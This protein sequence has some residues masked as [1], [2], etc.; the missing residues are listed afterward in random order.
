MTL[1]HRIPPIAVL[2]V[3]I[4]AI[5]QVGTSPEKGGGSRQGNPKTDVERSACSQKK[6]MSSH[7]FFHT[8]FFG[9]QLLFFLGFLWSSYITARN[10]DSTSKKESTSVSE[11]TILIFAQNIIIPLL[12]QCGLFIYT[13]VSENSVVFKNVIFCILWLN[14]M[15]WSRNICE[16]SSFASFYSFLVTFSE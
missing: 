6:V 8:L 5:Q 11:M 3:F 13:C 2:C 15:C 16:K 10:K 1:S 7:K 4:G 9:T 14:V 12:C